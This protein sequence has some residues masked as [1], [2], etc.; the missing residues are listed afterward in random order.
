MTTQVVI[1]ALR[2]D[3]IDAVQAIEVAAGRAFADVGLPEIADDEPSPAPTL[4][5]RAAAGRGWVVTDD[6][7]RSL[8]YV[9]VDIVDGAAHIE[10]VSVHPDAS[11]RG[12]G[13]ALVDHV[14]QWALDNEA[15]ALTLTTFRDV[16]WNGPYYERIGFR[17]LDERELGPG[18]RAVRAHEADEG[19]DPG[20]RVCMRRE[21]P[22]V[23]S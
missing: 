11:R 18:L 23:A 7:D 5:A 21:L 2:A 3:D 9:I 14:A 20:R 8:A 4:E 19:L 13:R 1:R 17:I 12:L 22:P 6:Q 10:Q 16:P 15:S